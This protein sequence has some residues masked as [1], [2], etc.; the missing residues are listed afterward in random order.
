MTLLERYVFKA[1]FGYAAGSLASL[2]LIVWIVQA[3]SRIDI[4][5][6]TASAAGNIFWIALMLLPGL[7]AGVLPFAVLIGAIQALNALN[8]G[9]ERAV[10]AAAGA[11][12]KTVARPIVLLGA[13]GGLLILFL[14]HVVG[15]YSASSFQN[16][17]RS[18]NADT[19][20]LFLQP[21][22]FERVQSDLVV[23]VGDANGSVIE[24]LFIAD[25]R[26]P[27]F[28]LTYF[29]REARVMDDGDRSALLLYD[30]QLHRRNTTDGGVS[31]IEFQTYAFDLA[32]L[33]PS[34]SGDW[35]RTSERSTAD[36]LFP[37][38]NDSLY[39]S[40]PLNLVEEV[41]D[42]MS[43]WLYA[44]AFAFWAVVV[45]GDPRT[46]RQGTGPAMFLGLSG[47][48]VLKALGFVALSLIEE[49][50]TWVFVSYLLPLGAIAFNLFLIWRGLGPASWPIT[51]WTAV[52]FDRVTA[53]LA[54][55]R[56][57]AF[58]NGVG[59]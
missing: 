38:P 58:Q 52:Q 20:T 25:T 11:S 1:A 17:L 59:R 9:S 26:D 29:A 8:A 21:G 55:L 31:V 37:D 5:K 48:L 46:N 32:E 36:L 42:R 10:I 51:E 6:T 7:I 44:I 13:I 12:P 22:R 34:S 53:L 49:G 3:L 24:S 39:Q 14:S 19:L 45:A 41:T 50:Y 23:S 4:I 2:V 43:S 18:I 57:A 28:D 15:P 40:K 30:G 27:A 16:G 33:R 56:P 47:G 54:R 35:I